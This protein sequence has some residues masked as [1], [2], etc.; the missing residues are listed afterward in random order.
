M[1]LWSEQRPAQRRIERFCVAS[2]QWLQTGNPAATIDRLFTSQHVGDLRSIVGV[3][4]VLLG[5]S[6]GLCL[7]YAVEESWPKV[8]EFWNAVKLF[9]TFFT[10]A[11]AVFG[12]IGA[13]AYKVGSIRL[14]V[15]DLFACEISTLCRVALITDTIGRLIT[16]IDRVGNANSGYAIPTAGMGPESRDANEGAKSRSRLHSPSAPQFTS[17]ENYFPVF[18]T[19]NRDLQALEARVVTNITS[20][21][22][23]MKTFRDLMRTAATLKPERVTLEGERPD[24]RHA[25]LWHN[26]MR[27]VIYMMFL[28]LEAGRRSTDDLVEFEP[29]HAEGS[30]V[31]L[32]SEL[33]A[34]LFLLQEFGNTEDMRARRL[35]LRRDTYQKLVPKLGLR[36]ERGLQDAT[37]RFAKAQATH[38][39]KAELSLRELE[40]SFW[41]QADEIWPDLDRLQGSLQA[42]NLGRTRDNCTNQH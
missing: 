18:E 3:A 1:D 28:S 36:V 34:Y 26:A 35:L 32:I 22:T 11:F 15:V 12:T 20:F 27:D 6:C 33:K 2:L 41:R 9:V 40:L 29:E 31:I 7:V 13:W 4:L 37:T 21:Y 16:R 25:D 14:G 38:R 8:F 39:P 17:S 19:N 10:P 30:I 24:Q 42:M 5:V 23:F